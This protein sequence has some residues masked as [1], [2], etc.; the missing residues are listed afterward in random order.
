MKY[1]NTLE[2]IAYIKEKAKKKTDG[3]Y[4]AR[5]LV[6]A[7]KNNMVTYIYDHGVYYQTL[8]GFLVRLGKIDW[9]YG[10]NS[11]KKLRDFVREVEK[12]Q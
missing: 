2:N 7:V 6:Y 5:G 11:I 10:E 12:K 9:S 8:Y 1:G 4:T 3:V